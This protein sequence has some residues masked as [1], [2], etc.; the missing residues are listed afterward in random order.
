[1]Q[2]FFEAT[3]S[4]TGARPSG[5]IVLRC[6]PVAQHHKTSG[7]VPPCH[8]GALAVNTSDNGPDP[9]TSVRWNTLAVRNATGM[10]ISS[11]EEQD[12]SCAVSAAG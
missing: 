8:S 11:L 7:D 4:A 12:P 5:D 1:M 6:N 3:L 2:E 9:M 10:A